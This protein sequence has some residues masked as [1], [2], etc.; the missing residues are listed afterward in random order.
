M[1]AEM[2][3]GFMKFKECGGCKSIHNFLKLLTAKK[4][5]SQ[6]SKKK[7]SLAL[8]RCSLSFRKYSWL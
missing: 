7:S 8:K 6:D 4:N 3:V 2:F 5:Y 1:D